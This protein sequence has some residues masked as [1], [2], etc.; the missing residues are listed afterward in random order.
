M[1][2]ERCF[3]IDGV[4]LLYLVVLSE[5]VLSTNFLYSAE[6]N[7]PPT[8]VIVIHPFILPNANIFKRKKDT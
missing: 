3:V 5:I 7:H 4:V 8:W 6:R 1:T 2:C